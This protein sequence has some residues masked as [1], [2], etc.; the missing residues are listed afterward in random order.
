[1]GMETMWCQ[2]QANWLTNRSDCSFHLNQLTLLSEYINDPTKANHLTQNEGS[3]ICLTQLSKLLSRLDKIPRL[4]IALF[5][6]CRPPR[7]HIQHTLEE[8]GLLPALI[9][10]LSLY[11]L[12]LPPSS[13]FV[14]FHDFKLSSMLNT[15][16]MG[17]KTTSYFYPSALKYQ[18]QIK[19][20]ANSLLFKLIHSK[21]V[22]SLCGITL[23]RHPSGLL[24]TG[25]I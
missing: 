5:K 22:L 20:L 2:W 25:C 16:V 1:M 17:T 14:I 13:S 9:L 10:D 4:Q 6:L 7:L 3:N 15:Y 21:S 23:E 11:H 24:G 19:T 12:Y 8:V 18:P